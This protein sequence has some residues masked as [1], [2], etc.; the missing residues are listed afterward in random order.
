MLTDPLLGA[1]LIQNKPTLEGGEAMEVVPMEHQLP[2]QREQVKQPGQAAPPAADCFGGH[3]HRKA[4][5][6]H[7]SASFRCNADS[8]ACYCWCLLGYALL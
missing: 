4:L 5:T 3:A 7:C 1:A 2:V 8:L 6:H